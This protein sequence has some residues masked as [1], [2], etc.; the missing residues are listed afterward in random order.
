MSN[1]TTLKAITGA[2]QEPRNPYLQF[3]DQLD[4]ARPQLL[5]LMGGSK[6]NVEKL[7]G[8][9]EQAVLGNM[10]LLN[11]DRKTLLQACMKAAND[12]LLPDGREAVLNIYNTKVKRN[13]RE[14]WIQQVQYL[15]MVAG[16]VKGLYAHPDVASVDAAA[17]YENDKFL[18]RRGDDPKLEH[19]PTMDDDSGKVICAY[20]V[21]KLKSG[22]IKRE[23][24]PRRDIEK[25]RAA[26][27]SGDGANSPWSKWY[28]QQAIKSVIKR[29]AKQLPRTNRFDQID[30]NDNEALGFVGTAESVANAVLGV[31]QTAGPALEHNPSDVLEAGPIDAQDQVPHENG[32]QD[33]QEPAGAAQVDGP[34]ATYADV[35]AGMLKAKT[36][37]A[38]DEASTLIEAVPTKAQRQELT[39]K[40]NAL[41]AELPA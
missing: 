3:K 6:D 38:L 5:G 16:Y 9:I 40:Y 36:R 11:A 15:P 27:K 28:D 2:A 1:A 41:R 33:G 37:E 14:E 35:L 26:S 17:V 13:G 39:S 20:L 7:I 32:Q 19:E 22:E 4:R 31:G 21:V 24:M 25:V 18:F 10:D 8:V 30:R 23:V 12:G 34:R 29:G